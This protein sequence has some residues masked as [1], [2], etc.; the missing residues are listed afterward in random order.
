MDIELLKTIL[1]YVAT[2]IAII[3][4]VKVAKIQS[5]YKLKEIRLVSELSEKQSA[6]KTYFETAFAFVENH[7]DS[8]LKDFR[9]SQSI[10]L[11]YLNDYDKSAVIETTESICGSGILNEHI[12]YEKLIKLSSMITGEIKD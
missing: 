12:H 1:P 2:A 8:T 3:A 9:K 5:E 7:N 10:L 4:P 6:L 11:I